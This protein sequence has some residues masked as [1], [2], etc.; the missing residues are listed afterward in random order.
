MFNKDLICIKN[1]STIH[2]K[3]WNVHKWFTYMNY[4]CIP[5]NNIYNEKKIESSK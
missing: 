2:I 4:E 5:V 1:I 3:T